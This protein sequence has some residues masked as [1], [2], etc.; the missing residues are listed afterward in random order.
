MPTV[1][2][3]LDSSPLN[4]SLPPSVESASLPSIASVVDQVLPAVVSITTQ[5]V[6]LDF[7]F[8]VVV[9]GAGSGVII[10]PDGY[11]VTNDHVIQGA[12]EITVTLADGRTFLAEVV[13]RDPEGD[14]AVIKIDADG[15]PTLSF[16]LSEQLRVGDWVIAVGNALG[17]QGGSSVTIG[18]VSALG[19]TIL[20]DQQRETYLFDTIQT[21]AA[22]N[23][24]NSGGPLVNLRGEVV[25]INTAIEGSAQGIGFAIASGIA[26]PTVADLID[27]GH[28]VRPYLGVGT[29]TLT[30]SIARQLGADVTGGVVIDGTVAG[31]P[32]SRA[33]L[34]RL[35]II[36][37]LNGQ[38]VIGEG[39]FRRILWQFQPGDTIIV[40]FVREG[41]TRTAEV[42]LAERPPTAAQGREHP[43]ASNSRYPY[44][45]L[46]PSVTSSPS[47]LTTS[48]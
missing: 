14:L 16:G 11:I 5:Q 40:E 22:I 7:F 13:G 30:P 35:D 6:Q 17:L 39:A 2:P 28:V 46:A 42:T 34:Q 20:T 47:S 38:A 4:V 15:L 31:T 41:K 10:R 18:I 45:R 3:A 19:R 29:V 24:G 33:G 37:K 1:T 44:T 43:L 25:G 32:A 21:D 36:T 23:P 26:E 9:P 48:V 27:Q 12:E 8:R